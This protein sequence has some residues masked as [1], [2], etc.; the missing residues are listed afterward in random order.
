MRRFLAFTL[1]LAVTVGGLYA[2]NAAVSTEPPVRF[3]SAAVNPTELDRLI[4]V[5][6]S[7]I[8]SDSTDWFNRAR[9]G[10]L[11]LERANHGGDLDDYDRAMVHLVAAVRIDR[12]PELSID[13]ARA[14]LAL[15]DFAGALDEI[16]T[17]DPNSVAR[18]TITFD[19]LLGL[20]RT[21][22][23]AGE[24]ATL[25]LRHPH[26]PV[27]LIRHAELA[28]HTGSPQQA[29]DAA[30]RALDRAEDAGL[31]S[32]DLG[33]YRSAAARYH[34]MFGSIDRARSLSEDVL[35]LAPSDPVGLLLHAR[36]VAADGDLTAAVTH[37]RQ[38]ATVSPD[39]AALG[40]LADVLLASGDAAGA[41]D[42]L[43][44][45]EVIAGL[46][47]PALRRQT[48][49]VLAD[50]GRR[51]DL[52]LSMAQAEL[53][54]RDDPYAHHLM[55]TVLHGLQRPAEAEA[56]AARATA[57]AD[58]VVWYRAGLI[59][60][61]N[62]DPALAHTRLQTALDLQPEFHPLWATHARELLGGL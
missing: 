4:G 26:E 31:P 51:L 24:L 1:T 59:A 16:E 25:A 43:A 18:G 3:R 44:T 11:Y 33:F 30:E 57:I 29:L 37:A 8:D 15:H 32:K 14:R 20:G 9:L 58:P 13:L 49:Q 35:D 45:V 61:D 38:A 48:A 46:G 55:A 12:S 52:A 54:E 17:V 23:A 47:Q 5:F 39:P 2:A 21:D 10:S 34:L 19:A 50:H 36:A 60:L 56:H 40:F 6:A 41:E 62:G 22:E 42:Q 27:I 7:R 53:A 28:L